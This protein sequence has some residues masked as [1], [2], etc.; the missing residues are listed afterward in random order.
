VQ[1]LDHQDRGGQRHV[2]AINKVKA[3]A[4][5]FNGTNVT[6]FD[7][8]IIMIFLGSLLSSYKYFIV[9][10]EWRALSELILDFVTMRLLHEL[11]RRKENE[12]YEDGATLV[13]K[14]WRYV[15]SRSF[16]KKVYFNCGKK[17][18]LQEMFS[19]IH[20]KNNMHLHF[21]L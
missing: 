19:I 4:D 8:Y 12:L 18:T 9:L 10:F 20:G 15:S 14:Q 11:L 16:S 3:L 21:K 7:G 13:T 17:A 6:I 2:S 1:I 5:Q